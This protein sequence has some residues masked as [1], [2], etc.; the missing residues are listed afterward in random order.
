MDVVHRG[1]PGEEQ[2]GDISSVGE[3]ESGNAH[4]YR[5]IKHNGSLR[6]STLSL[7]QTVEM[8]DDKS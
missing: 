4:K 5:H 2:Y 6:W 3:W 8:I 1:Q 7:L